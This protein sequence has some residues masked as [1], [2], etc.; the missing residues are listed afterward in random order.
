M[1]ILHFVIDR[2]EHY[3]Y[4]QNMNMIHVFDMNFVHGWSVVI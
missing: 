3:S 2:G 1:N 4:N